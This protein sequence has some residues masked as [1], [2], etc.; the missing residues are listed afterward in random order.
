M[1]DETTDKS[2]QEQLTMV[3]RWVDKNLTVSEDFL[4]LYALDKTDAE[5]IV[6]VLLDA[7]VSFR[8]LLAKIRG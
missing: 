7:L 6:T 8:E 1:V 5:S 3:I 2:N 4:S